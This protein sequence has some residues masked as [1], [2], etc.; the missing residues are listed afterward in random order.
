[1]KK[2]HFILSSAVLLFLNS[3]SQNIN[4]ISNLPVDNQ[5]QQ[6]SVDKKLSNFRSDF[7]SA[8]SKARNW[9]LSAELVKAESR[10]VSENGFANWTFYFKSPFKNNA[11]R[12]DMGFG[13]E[14][15]NSFF[16]REI[17]EFDIRV[18]VDQ[19]IE[20]AKK[21]GLKKFPISEIVLEKRSVFTEWQIRNSDGTFRISAEN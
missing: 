21:Q 11:F 16:G 17:R 15:P 5:V 13:N 19:A 20:K 6:S 3:C 9:D 4:P 8:Q 7:W 12:V 18:D 1:M 10:F 2:T 14:V